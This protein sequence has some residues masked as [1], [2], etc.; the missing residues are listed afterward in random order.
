MSKGAD[1]RAAIL[2]AGMSVAATEGLEAL[3]IG[4]LADRV[5]LSK[6]GLFAHF[7]SKELLQLQVLGYA[8][9]HFVSHVM[10][11]ALGEP[12]GEP[13]IV[14]LLE[15]WLTWGSS[16][17][18]KGGCVFLQAAA[19]YDDRPGVVRDLL[20]QTQRDWR[21]ALVRAADLAVEEGHFRAGLDTQQF[22]FEMYA[23]IMA[24][25]FYQRLLDDPVTPSRTRAAFERLLE[26]CR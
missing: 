22:A 26:S 25:H 16:P 9:E 14:A 13:R 15:N 7:R 2:D 10:Q 24:H 21:D 5:G 19:E 11:P 23:L 1:T 20:V 6:S 8:R 12:R 17:E 4:R 3:S 18:R